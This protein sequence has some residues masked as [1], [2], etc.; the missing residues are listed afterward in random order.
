MS[1]DFTMI[2]NSIKT[3]IAETVL[4][5]NIFDQMVPLRYEIHQNYV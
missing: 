5:Q 3:I 2:V 1:R 4:D